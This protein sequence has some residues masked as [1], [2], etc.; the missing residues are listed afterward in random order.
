MSFS[1]V[2]SQAR[3]SLAAIA[4]L[5]IIGGFTVAQADDDDRVPSITVS[6]TGEMTADPDLAYVTVGVVTEGATAKEAVDANNTAMKELRA[7]LDKLDIAERDRQTS[8]FSVSPIYQ[9]RQRPQPGRVITPEN[10]EPQIVSYRVTNDVRIRVRQISRVGEILDAVVQSGSNRI[11]GISFSVDNDEHFMNEA[12][13]KA[14]KSARA[15]AELLC[16]AA[17]TKLGKV[18]E[19]REAGSGGGSPRPEMMMAAVRS[20]PISPGEQTI[21]ASVTMTF[22]IVSE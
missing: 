1:N 15:K 22:E 8:Q 16:D 21:S 2:F 20:V 6:G 3:R 11:N 17:G 12:R 14:V 10:N 5:A 7:Q 9:Q 13:V 18:L 4:M 19:I